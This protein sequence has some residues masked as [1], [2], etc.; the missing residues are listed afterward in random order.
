MPDGSAT[1]I[2]SKDVD[3]SSA[4]PEA[5]TDQN[6]TLRRTIGGILRQH[7]GSIAAALALG[8]VLLISLAQPAGGSYLAALIV[9]AGGVLFLLYAASR[10][11]RLLRAQEEQHQAAE[12]ANRRKS[13]FLSHMSHELRT[14]L[15]AIL[16]FSEVM[17]DGCLGGPDNPK[18]R[19]YA[20]DIHYSAQHMLSVVNNILDLAKVESGKWVMNE[21]E[22]AL[23]ELLAATQRLAHERANREQVQ[24]VIRPIPDDVY[25]HGDQRVLC[26]ALLNLTIN[27]IKFAGP[28][29][30]VALGINRGVD[31]T[32][33]IHVRDGGPGMNADQ[34]ARAMRP[35][36]APLP[37]GNGR[38]K[39][40]DTGLGLPLAAAFA[41]LHGGALRFDSPAAGGTIARLCLPADRVRSLARDGAKVAE[42]SR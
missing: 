12:A 22:I 37:D 4:A 42:I 35:F 30:E 28:D 41:E 6:A 32:L 27:A 9:T 25:L 7:A 20:G 26:Q 3:M 17:R 8:G 33:E 13:E 31:G 14:P 29:R 36:E 15:N 1:L 24:L 18:N 38:R 34:I 19:E 40:H 21:T 11:E 39:K 5:Q 16:G 2:M 23:D 10:G